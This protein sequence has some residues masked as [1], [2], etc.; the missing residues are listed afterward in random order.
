MSV[1]YQRYWEPD[2]VR[3]LE[4]LFRRRLQRLFEP[5][6]RDYAR[7]ESVDRVLFQRL[8]NAAP[9][10]E[11]NLDGYVYNAL[12]MSAHDVMRHLYGRPRPP[13]EMRRAGKEAVRIFELF[14]VEGRRVRDIA[15]E[16]G[17]SRKSVTRW[18]D[19]LIARG[20]CHWR[21]TFVENPPTR[22]LDETWGVLRPALESD[23]PVPETLDATLHEARLRRL[24]GARAALSHQDRRL[25]TLLHVNGFDRASVATLLG[26]PETEV[27][28]RHEALMAMLE[29]VCDARE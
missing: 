18:T 22:G 11:D 29:R 21:P 24:K 23:D 25:L 4:R 28:T 12:S 13:A 17:L 8:P 9:K 6:D 27:A 7:D 1:W 2:K 16:L 14:A 3:W 26:L 15:D 10:H 19:W 5:H 20:K